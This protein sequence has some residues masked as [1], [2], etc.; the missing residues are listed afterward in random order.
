MP[1]KIGRAANEAWRARYAPHVALQER[2]EQ[3]DVTAEIK[4]ILGVESAL[5]SSLAHAQKRFEGL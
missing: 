5:A 3:R 1:C 4:W 2:V